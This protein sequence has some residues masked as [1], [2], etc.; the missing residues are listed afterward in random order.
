MTPESRFL[1]DRMLGPLTR[2]LRLLGYDTESADCLPPGNPK[3]DTELLRW[4][5]RE[6]RILLT[7]DRELA[8][9]AGDRGI[10]IG[11]KEILDQ[12][13]FL[14]ERGQI[15]LPVRLIRC[16]ICNTLLEDAPEEEIQAANYAPADQD[17]LTF[18]WCPSCRRLYW[19]GS[20]TND[21]IGRIET[22]SQR[23]EKAP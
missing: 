9:R 6:G 19:M 5:E 11:E 13:E 8:G 10:Y 16:S 20:H 7:R 12:L 1:V 23:S 2:Y 14:K 21:V 3:E 18:R 17:E 22:L 15:D 4:A